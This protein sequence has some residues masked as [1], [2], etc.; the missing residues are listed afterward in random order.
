MKFWKTVA[1]F[2]PVDPGYRP[3]GWRALRGLN[4]LTLALAAPVAVLW[5]AEGLALSLFVGGASG[6]DALQHQWRQSLTYL[7]LLMPLLVVTTLALNLS[8][9]RGWAVRVLALALAGCLGAAVFAMA[10]IPANCMVGER[11]ASSPVCRAPVVPLDLQQLSTLMRAALASTLIVALL[12]IHRRGLESAA[13]LNDSRL[14]RARI[15]RQESEARLRALQSQI[16]PH[17]LFN[18]LAHIQRLH[19]VDP[20]RGASMLHSLIDYLR[21]ALPQM[22]EPD[23]TLGRELA[24]TRAYLNVQQI[25]M[26]DRLRVD[27]AVPDA[28]LDCRVPP[29]MVLTLTENAVKHGLSPKGEGGTL[30]IRVRRLGDRLEITVRDDGVGL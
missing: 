15:Q 1:P 8:A 30:H 22:R 5:G 4:A 14:H 12:T 26:G 21:S 3:F 16:E 13:L 19:E 28:L 20:P 7:C 17:F 29:M 2:M 27:M 11:Q 6:W 9:D 10:W 18:T 23:T 25:R 24:L